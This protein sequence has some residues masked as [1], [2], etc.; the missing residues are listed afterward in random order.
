MQMNT[1]VKSIMDIGSRDFDAK[2]LHCSVGPAACF[3]DFLKYPPH[4]SRTFSSRG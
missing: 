3:H 4:A 2:S 1:A